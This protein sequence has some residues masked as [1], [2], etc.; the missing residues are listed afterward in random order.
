M[1]HTHRQSGAYLRKRKG[2]GKNDI[3]HLRK[4]GNHLITMPIAHTNPQRIESI[5]NSSTTQRWNE[6]EKEFNEMN[7]QWYKKRPN[8]CQH[9]A[10][11]LYFLRWIQRQFIHRILV[12]RSVWTFWP[13][14]L[15]T[16]ANKIYKNRNQL[17]C[18]M[19]TM[20][21]CDGRMKFIARC[22]SERA[23]YFFANANVNVKK[24]EEE[25]SRFSINFMPEQYVRRTI[26]M[27]KKGSCTQQHLQRRRRTVRKMDNEQQHT[28]D[29]THTSSVGATRN[30]QRSSN[31][32]IKCKT[33]FKRPR[34][35]YMR[36]REK[37]ERK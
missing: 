10:C 16:Q 35:T 27:R 4:N 3:L 33:L 25:T 24:E 15:S 18:V 9:S 22:D 30:T 1:S 12:S 17:F 32:N 21:I 7:S 8:R 6:K 19:W 11:D 37:K 23:I 31:G 14:S 26:P 2:Q 13:V 20:N 36:R 28:C 5:S 34:F 29:K